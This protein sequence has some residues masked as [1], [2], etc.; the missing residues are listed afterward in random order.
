MH[1]N[2]PAQSPFASTDPSGAPVEPTP[3]AEQPQPPRLGILHLMVLTACVAVW[4]GAMRTIALAAD[5]LTALGSDPFL[6]AGTL[7]GIGGGV[8][9]SGLILLVSRRLRRIPFPVHPGEYLLVMSAIG[10][11]L[12]SAIN[13]AFL[14]LLRTEPTSS[15]LWWLGMGSV[16]ATFVVNAAVLIWAFVHVKT[17]RWRVFLLSIPVCHVLGYGLMFTTASWGRPG[18]LFFV[19]QGVTPFAVSVVLSAV[20]IQDHL[21]GNRYPWSHWMGVALRLWFDFGRIVSYVWIIMTWDAGF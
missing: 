2:E 3:S 17:W 5:Q 12:T 4:M 10:F 13:A 15:T 7:N 11:I 9:L 14:L 18:P 19:I 16:I 8:A 6:A 1:S 21:K 20:V